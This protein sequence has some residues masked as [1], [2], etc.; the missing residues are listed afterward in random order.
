MF[1]VPSSLVHAAKL[2]GECVHLDGLTSEE[3]PLLPASVAPQDKE[4]YILA[5]NLVLHRWRSDVSAYLSLD[6]AKAPPMPKPLAAHAHIAWHFLDARGFIN[7][8]VAPPILERLRAGAATPHARGSV[9][10]LGAGLA[11][12]AAAHQLLKL[13][14]RVVVLEAKAHAGGRVHTARLEGGGQQAVADLGGAVITGVDGNPLAVLARQLRIPLHRIEAES[15]DCP[16]YQANG[17]PVSRAIDAE[18]SEAWVAAEEEVLEV[19][20]QYA[21]DTAEALSLGTLMRV[22]LRE[23]LRPGHA[24]RPMLQWLYS[25]AEFSAAALATDLSATRWADDDLFGYSGDHVWLPG[26]NA[27]LVKALAEEVPILYNTAAQEVH[28]GDAGVTVVTADGGA[29]AAD[30]CLVTVP[31]GVLKAGHICFRPPLPA[32]KQKAIDALGF[33]VLNKVVLLFP[34]QWWETRDTFGHVAGDDEDP[35]WFYLWYCFPGISGGHLIAALVSGRAAI[36]LESMR[37]EEVIARVMARLRRYHPHHT[38]PDPLAAVVT[39]WGRDPH[40]L[41]SYS[42]VP[43]GCAGADD[44]RELA[45]SVD[46]RL[47]FAGEAT[48]FQYPAQMHGAYDSG[49]R[50]ASKLHGTLQ[51]RARSAG[52]D[53]RSHLD[54]VAAEAELCHVDRMMRVGLLLAAEFC[55]GADVQLASCTA[56]HAVSAAAAIRQWAVLRVDLSLTRGLRRPLSPE[57]HLVPLRVIMEVMELSGSSEDEL[58]FLLSQCEPPVSLHNRSAPTAEELGLMEELLA[59]RNGGA[60]P[61]KEL[62]VAEL[63]Q[64][65]AKADI[66]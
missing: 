20:E 51:Q 54:G 56:I 14:Y 26:G 6:D 52:A 31:L 44:Y 63:V 32:S 22:K 45:R 9:I 27:R 57:Y 42:S 35:G 47:F 17:E 29:L 50:E 28:Y 13:G 48:T 43:P 39:Q 36:E 12:L 16:L 49:L 41:G 53:T 62:G 64:K 61:W 5:R 59:H 40:T 37:D 18:A 8:G 34:H 25:N 1:G 23:Q 4:K 19:G 3:E 58:E 33:G 30:A 24:L 2:V 7:F 60:L 55:K 46:G 11:G 21:P 15:S 65:W 38:V 10:I 66:H